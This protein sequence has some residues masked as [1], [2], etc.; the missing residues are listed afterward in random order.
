ME[1]S[2]SDIWKSILVT[3]RKPIIQSIAADNAIFLCSELYAA[4]TK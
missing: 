2:A 4:H 1:E 3:K